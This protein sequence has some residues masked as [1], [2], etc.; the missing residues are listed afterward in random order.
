VSSGASVAQAAG[1]ESSP[2]SESVAMFALPYNSPTLIGGAFYERF[3]RGAF[4]QQSQDWRASGVQ[5]RFQHVQE[6]LLTNTL[7]GTLTIRDERDG[8]YAAAMLP[9]TLGYVSEL[10]K[11]GD[12]AEVS[13]GFKAIRDEW[14]TVGGIPTRTVLEARLV[15]ISLCAAGSAAYSSTWVASR[16]ALQERLRGLRSRM[17]EHRA[18]RKLSASSMQAIQMAIDR[19]GD[20]LASNTGEDA[21]E[22]VPPPGVGVKPKGRKPANT[23]E[24]PE[25]DA[26]AIGTSRPAVDVEAVDALPGFSRMTN[27]EARERLAQL[28]QDE[29][30][31]R[32][33]DLKL[34][35]RYP[36][37]RRTLI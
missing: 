30:H 21:D 8:L 20:L 4:R 23:D 36:G 34:W 31:R 2:K 14:T 17:D 5:L 6:F 37:G 15:E 29:M 25:N 16:S 13:I 9:Q 22:E 28:E 32:L 3:V 10:V 24:T 27:E 1:S 35:R 33:V 7:S 12:V 18:G 26:P 11:R 19:L